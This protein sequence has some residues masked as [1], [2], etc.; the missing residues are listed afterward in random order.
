MKKTLLLLFAFFSMTQSYS[1][2]LGFDEVDEF[3]DNRIIQL[4]A[5]KKRG[6]TQTDGITKD[7]FKGAIFLTT[8]ITKFTDGKIYTYL[9]LNIHSNILLC[10]GG[11]KVILLFEDKNKITLDQISELDCSK[12]SDVKYH[13]TQKDINIIKKSNLEKLRI[14]TRDGYID[15]EIKEKAK[16]VIR[17]TLQMTADKLK[18]IE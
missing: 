8:K 1:Q 12:I 6:W 7:I 14:Y 3:T 11:D 4:N 18:E 2:V 16:P 17:K 13:L 10:F 15:Y 5:S 9:N